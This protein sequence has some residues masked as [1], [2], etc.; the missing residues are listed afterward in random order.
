MLDSSRGLLAGGLDEALKDQRPTLQR[1]RRGAVIRC[2]GIVAT[3]E[4]DQ[5]SC[6]V[7]NQRCG[8][9]AVRRFA[10]VNRWHDRKWL[11][12]SGA[13][14][15]WWSSYPARDSIERLRNPHHS[16]ACSSV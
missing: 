10:D 1:G 2:A 7:M 13:N 6:S 12:Y 4:Q 15:V 5:S 11:H 16:L 9:M 3:R 14:A 8:Y